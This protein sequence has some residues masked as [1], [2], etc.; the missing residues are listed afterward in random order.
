MWLEHS[1]DV[2]SIWQKTEIILLSWNSRTSR[3]YDIAISVFIIKSKSSIGLD[4]VWHEYTKHIQLSQ[5]PSVKCTFRL[6][7]TT[8]MK[9]NLV[10]LFIDA[11]TLK[12]LFTLKWRAMSSLISCFTS[13]PCPRM[14]FSTTATVII[15]H[16]SS[17]RIYITWKNKIRPIEICLL[18]TRVLLSLLLLLHG[19]IVNMSTCNSKPPIEMWMHV[20]IPLPQHQGSKYNERSLAWWSTFN[21]VMKPTKLSSPNLDSW[22]TRCLC[23]TIWS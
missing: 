19:K 4:S 23:S 22:I 15:Y 21:L 8:N 1:T 17:H 6:C 2:P 12:E 14:G 10:D 20:V 5:H 18:K 13:W 11:E 9:S 7:L 16:H 3:L